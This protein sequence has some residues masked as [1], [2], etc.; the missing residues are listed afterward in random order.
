MPQSVWCSRMISSVPS[1][2][3]DSESERIASSVTMPPGIAEDVGLALVRP[4][5]R[6]GIRR[7]SMQASTATRLEGSSREVAALS[8]RS[9]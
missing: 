8:K 3:W 2:F 7:V 9:A 5:I 6:D 1:R 4:R